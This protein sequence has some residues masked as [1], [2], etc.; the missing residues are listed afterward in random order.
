M[1]LVRVVWIIQN[2][3]LHDNTKFF[4][5]KNVIKLIYISLKILFYIGKFNFLHKKMIKFNKLFKF[6]FEI[7]TNFCDN[8]NSL[9]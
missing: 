8:K 2:E 1:Y 7:I 3:N 4:K 9:N 6:A 5:L